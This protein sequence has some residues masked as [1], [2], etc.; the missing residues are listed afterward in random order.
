[1]S[2]P[3]TVGLEGG[4]ELADRSRAGPGPRHHPTEPV[5]GL[6]QTRVDRFQARRARCRR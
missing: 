2:G 6:A 1:M 4:G 5:P 3:C